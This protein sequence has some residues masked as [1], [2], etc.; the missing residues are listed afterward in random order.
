MQKKSQFLTG[1]V[2]VGIWFLIAG[3]MAAAAADAGGKHHL[4]IIDDVFHWR[5]FLAPFHNVVLH[6]PIA[7][8]TMALI[9]EMY[10]WRW[11]GPDL[12]RVIRLVLLLGVGSAAISILFGVMRAADGDYDVKILASHRIFGFAV[13]ILIVATTLV[14]WLA[15]RGGGHPA[16]RK[17]Y[18]VLLITNV[19]SVVV[20][21]HQGGNLTHG[22]NYLVKNAPPVIREL[23]SSDD[24][25]AP[26]D[27][28]TDEK[29]R[30]YVERIQPIL[31]SRCLDC[32]NAEK[33]KGG[34]RLD[35]RA[36]ALK[37]GK[38]GDPAIKPGD[39]LNSKLIRLV[40]L[41][42]SN[43]DVMPPEGKK[44]LSGDEILDII[45]WIQAGASFAEKEAPA[46]P[47]TESTKVEPEAKEAVVVDDTKPPK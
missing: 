1:A 45:R 10:S 14:H 43:D 37:G 17:I 31:Q 38:S 2:V 27:A 12:P 13:G 42:A 35:Q 33:Q 41:P 32:H 5:P 46:A 6:F 7:F 22:S 44:L 16:L 47:P 18:Q 40:T 15:Y 29:D 19:V 20:A 30:L 21:G 3:A 9:L 39:P 26:S 36:F 34:L 4:V 8:V 24:D 23:L 28:S 11:P 25:V